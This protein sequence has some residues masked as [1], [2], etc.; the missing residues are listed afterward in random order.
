MLSTVTSTR[1]TRAA[2]IVRQSPCGGGPARDHGWKIVN[3]R[4]HAGFVFLFQ[5]II[6]NRQSL[7]GN[8][9]PR[10]GAK[11]SRPL[12]MT[13]LR[14]KQCTWHRPSILI[15]GHVTQLLDPSSTRHWICRIPY[16]PLRGE[17]QHRER[18]RNLSRR[19]RASLDINLRNTTSFNSQT[20]FTL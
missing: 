4:C 11:H 8:P 6:G 19:S 9:T 7:I 16:L 15:C 5:S 12:Q 2:R 20:L 14:I 18:S 1:H 13:G 17:P 10:G 3:R